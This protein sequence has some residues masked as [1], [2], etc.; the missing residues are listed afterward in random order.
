MS[1]PISSTLRDNSIKIRWMPR[2]TLPFVLLYT[3]LWL[4]VGREFHKGESDLQGT[5]ADVKSEN[6][7]PHKDYGHHCF[8]ALTVRRLLRC[9]VRCIYF[10]MTVR[11]HS[12]T[13]QMP[14]AN[15]WGGI[16]KKAYRG[17]ERFSSE[18][19]VERCWSTLAYMNI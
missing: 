16:D 14:I 6:C 13:K 8:V 19:E 4:P 11:Q 3:A 15:G 9:I 5:E 18:T 10:T 7:A 17:N 12:R 1:H 2:S